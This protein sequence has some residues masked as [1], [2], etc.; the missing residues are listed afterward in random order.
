MF[1]RKCHSFRSV[2]QSY[3]DV[4]ISFQW[5]G[6]G[7]GSRP[8]RGEI[9][10][11]PQLLHSKVRFGGSYLYFQLC[12]NYFSRIAT[13]LVFFLTSFKISLEVLKLSYIGK[14][15]GFFF[16]T[17][18]FHFYGY[19]FWSVIIVRFPEQTK[20]F[21]TVYFWKTRFRNYFTC[22]NF[23]RISIFQQTSKTN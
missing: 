21:D 1:K 2:P 5:L 9:G 19:G 4:G 12:S 14:K 15:G 10:L 22:S 16:R 7:R 23:F 13:F 11:W 17:R 18:Y 8:L 20:N 6:D 3:H